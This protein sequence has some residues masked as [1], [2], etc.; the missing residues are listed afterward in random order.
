MRPSG[1]C[2]PCAPESKHKDEAKC[3]L[4]P[5]RNLELI[6]H[7]QWQSKNEEVGGNV[8]ARVAPVDAEAVAVG[9]LALGDVP[10]SRERDTDCEERDDDPNMRDD[11]DAEHDFGR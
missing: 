2:C 10:D 6:E 9:G 8:D 4:L 1:G 3:N 5:L 7:T 11:D